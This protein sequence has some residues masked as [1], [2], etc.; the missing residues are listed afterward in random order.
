MAKRKDG[1]N[2]SAEIRALL[3]TT[4][5]IGAKEA[6][7]KLAENG[8]EISEGLFYFVKGQLKG[9]KAGK[10][11]ARQMVAQFAVTNGTVDPLATILKI[12]HL[13][14]EVG[15]MKKLKALVEALTE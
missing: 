10:R 1:V 4:P 9:R 14:N 6:V 7:A 2:K 3:K 8:I 11:K 13:G 12:K 5:G 15:G